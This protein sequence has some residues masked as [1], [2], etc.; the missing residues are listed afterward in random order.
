MQTLPLRIKNVVERAVDTVLPPRCMVTGEIVEQQGMIS[1]KAWVDIDFIA[2]PLCACCGLPFEYQVEAGTH[3]AAC[4]SRPLPFAS[5]R[6][7]LKYNDASRALVLGFK[8]ADK[9]YAVRAFIPWMRRAGADMLSQADYLVPVP[10]HRWRLLSRRYN[11][12]GVIAQGLSRET[13][14]PV[15]LDALERIRATPSQGYLKAKERHDN[16]KSAFAVHPRH[17]E[18][19]RGKTIV[20]VDDVY[21]T[22]ATVKECAKILLGAG[23]GQV[24]VLTL[25]RA[26]REDY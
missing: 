9:T 14:V 24:H 11:Q 4:L 5:A 18:K 19:L 16:V 15:V 22:G 1:P 23:A 21:T 8:H 12:S 17:R 3:C 10:L 13:G 2:D 7:A 25:A 6:S 20:L 26:V